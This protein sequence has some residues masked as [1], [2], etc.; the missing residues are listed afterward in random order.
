MAWLD[1]DATPIYHTTS[2]HNTGSP[3]AEDVWRE[4]FNE[5]PRN[6]PNDQTGLAYWVRR[7]STAGDLLIVVVHT[8][9]SGLGGNGHVEHE[10]LD[11]TLGEHADARW[12][13]VAGHYPAFPVN[14]YDLQPMWRLD[15]RDG[16]AFW[17]TLVR[18]GVLAYFCSHIIAF[19]AQVH[20][21]VLQVCT[22][23]AGTV[24]GPGGF[25]PGATEYLHFV[26]VALDGD[27]CRLRTIDDTGAERERI[28]WPPGIPEQ[29]TPLP[30]GN[31]TDALRGIAWPERHALLLRFEGVSKRGADVVDQTLLRG[32][33]YGFPAVW[34]GV[35]RG[36]VE[37]RL[38]P[39]PGHPPAT[40]YGPPVAADAPFDITLALRGDMG[41]GGVLYLKDSGWSSLHTDSSM[42]CGR[43]PT[44]DRWS[45][46]HGPSGPADR[47]FRSPLRASCAAMPLSR[48]ET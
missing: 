44:P 39:A 45:A 7:E 1:R 20:R 48:A 29:W 26:D 47:P 41:P 9:S 8:S 4:V 32:D 17:E 12:K 13:I 11:Q 33:E 5:L 24:A 35:S 10:W 30:L 2:N 18:H 19:D 37:V 21:G 28:S 40:W 3:M 22:G 14:G 43:T 46:G 38:Q 34:I 27:G 16:E 36:A 15:A 25:M 42:G 23:G 31:A 6:G